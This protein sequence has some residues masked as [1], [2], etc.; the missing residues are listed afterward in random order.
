MPRETEG[1]CK[2]ALSS[3][4]TSP[5]S[6]DDALDF[7]AGYKV[8]NDV[9][10][11]ELQFSDGQ[12]FRGKGMDT[13]CPLLNRIV[14][15]SELGAADSLRVVQRLNGHLLQDAPTSDMV[16]DVP[17]LVEYVSEALTL[18]AGDVILTGTPPGVGYFRD[19]PVG[20]TSGDVVEVEVEGI[21]CLTNPVISSHRN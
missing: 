7:V 12:W 20:L 18:E 10:A 14:P 8:G 1:A 3:A 17:T 16:F 5:S 21:G 15:V 13:F 9:S 11:R 4:S 6:I 19:T 2:F